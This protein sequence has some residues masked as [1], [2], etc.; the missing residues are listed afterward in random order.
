M[1]LELERRLIEIDLESRQMSHSVLLDPAKREELGERAKALLSELE[2]IAPTIEQRTWESQV[3]SE[4]RLDLWYVLKPSPG[5]SL[6][7]GHAIR[8]RSLLAASK[9]A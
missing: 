4:S 8:K 7:L 3:V 6:R 1:S 5:V 2:A 9:G